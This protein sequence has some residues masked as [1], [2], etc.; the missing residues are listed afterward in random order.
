MEVS[1]PCSLSAPQIA[2]LSNQPA[3]PHADY[4]S[5]E[6]ASLQLGAA[7]KLE[8]SDT[9]A[10]TPGSA[11]CAPAELQSLADCQA[12]APSRAGGTGGKLKEVNAVSMTTQHPFWLTFNDKK[13]E[14]QFT[15]SFGE[16]L[17][18]VSA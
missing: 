17:L 18:V 9:Q 4:V 5:T 11:C 1:R 10:T 12:Q 14:Q 6:H 16:Q 2:R 7:D 8:H 3:K 13:L 15:R